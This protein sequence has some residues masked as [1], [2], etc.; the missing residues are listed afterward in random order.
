M[1]LLAPVNGRS[2]ARYSCGNDGGALSPVGRSIAYNER[3]GEM[4]SVVE[5]EGSEEYGGER[6]Y[7]DAR[8]ADGAGD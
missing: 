3:R 6:A 5:S 1:R 4:G 2:T 7:S 8:R